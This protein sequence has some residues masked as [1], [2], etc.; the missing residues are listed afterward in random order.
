MSVQKHWNKTRLLSWISTPDPRYQM[1]GG[2]SRGSESRAVNEELEL[3]FIHRAQIPALPVPA[4]RTTWNPT[5]FVNWVSVAVQT[6]KQTRNRISHM[7][8]RK[9]M[10]PR[11]VC[12][13]SGMG[14]GAAI[15]GRSRE[16]IAWGGAGGGGAW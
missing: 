2:G 10:K 8:R 15:K 13:R 6:N 9:E 16:G 3:E 12:K 4:L 1:G 14:P 7:L 5:I 11:V